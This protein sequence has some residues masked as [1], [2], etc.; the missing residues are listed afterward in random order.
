MDQRRRMG[1]GVAGA[2]GQAGRDQGADHREHHH[3]EP[4]AVVGRRVADRL[5]GHR[6]EPEPHVDRHQEIAGRL[7]TALD[8]RDPEREG[9]RPDEHP[10]HPGAHHQ[11][12]EDR[13]RQARRTEQQRVS[14]G[15]DQ[16]A[17]DQQQAGAS[18]V[19]Q[20]SVPRPAEQCR[21]RHRAHHHPGGRLRT[22]EFVDDEPRQQRIRRSG[23]REVEG[24][25]QAEH[26]ELRRHQP[27]RRRSQAWMDRSVGH[28]GHSWCQAPTMRA[29]TWL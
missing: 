28:R 17:D 26:P 13:H 3:D 16:G 2:V 18:T 14:D 22:A 1:A 11:A 24:G 8:R 6:P 7:R 9:R 27:S 25:R 4:G 20:P 10:R 21:E 23:T 15:R 29:S 19:G 12:G 5:T